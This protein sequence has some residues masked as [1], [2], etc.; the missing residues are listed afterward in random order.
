MINDVVN[1]YFHDQASIVRL[2]IL[3]EEIGETK[4]DTL[5]LLIGE[6]FSDND[7]GI[8]AEM[9]TL[10]QQIEAECS[11]NDQGI[12]DEMDTLNQ[13]IKAECSDNDQGISDEMNTSNQQIEAKFSNDDSNV[14]S[15]SEEA[16]SV[17]SQR[18]NC[19][20]D[21]AEAIV[22]SSGDAGG[23][24]ADER[25]EVESGKNNFPLVAEGHVQEVRPTTPV[26]NKGSEDIVD[27]VVSSTLD[28]G[29]KFIVEGTKV[30]DEGEDYIIEK[31][32]YFFEGEEV[33]SAVVSNDVEH[34]AESEIKSQQTLSVPSKNSILSNQKEVEEPSCRKVD[35][36]VLQACKITLNDGVSENSETET[37]AQIVR[38]IT[39]V[40]HSGSEDIVDDIVSSSDEE[41]NLVIDEE[42]KVEKISAL[43][44]DVEYIAESEVESQLILAAPS[45]KRTLDRNAGDEPL[46]KREKSALEVEQNGKNTSTEC[47][48]FKP[49]PET[50][51]TEKGESPV[52]L[53]NSV[54]KEA[55]TYLRQKEPSTPV[56]EPTSEIEENLECERPSS[57]VNE[58][59]TETENNLAEIPTTTAIANK[60][61][62]LNR[63]EVDELP[64]MKSDLGIEQTGKNTV[65]KFDS[66]P[67][68]SK[69]CES[70]QEEIPIIPVISSDTDDNFQN[71]RPPLL[72]SLS[73]EKRD[74]RPPL[75]PSP[76]VKASDSRSESIRV[77]SSVK[78]SSRLPRKP[79]TNSQAPINLPTNRM[80]GPHHPMPNQP[81]PIMFAN[82]Q[83]IPNS[84]SSQGVRNNLPVPGMRNTFNNQRMQQMQNCRPPMNPNL[85][86]M[87]PNLQQ[88]NLNMKQVNL[89]MGQVN[90]NL[91]QVNPNLQQV[92]LNMQQMNP[93]MQQMNF[94]MPQM[95]LKMQ[96]MNPNLQQMNL[97]MPQMNLKMQQMIPNMQQMIPNMQLMNI[98]FQ[99]FNNN[100]PPSQMPHQFQNQAGPQFRQ[101]NRLQLSPF[102]MK[103]RHPQNNY[104]FQIIKRKMF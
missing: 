96:Q 102:P 89:N 54:E 26:R 87:N 53:V 51:V 10:N 90:P 3:A 57:L 21:Q 35:L 30:I 64:R 62:T 39:Q 6:L 95:N 11:D 104:P 73:P 12:S 93:N 25:E 9:N 33:D 13:Q 20:S 63:N 47:D 19:R 97:N 5:V 31:E 29:E 15:G 48:N 80:F 75:L 1:F 94:N 18:S 17:Q 70:I 34:F 67:E 72:E 98:N 2:Y 41:G 78:Q 56:N 61:Q 99:P 79:S 59:I 83:N 49:S 100:C 65:N 32:E 101:N 46:R 52:T 23:L 22:I 81:Q 24:V 82:N 55:Q 74:S 16:E 37:R 92:N 8:S 42:K 71:K 77:A 60:K 7:Q 86:Q 36:G 4:F 85:Q 66:S 14:L 91:Q 44:N 84:Q 58:K 40:K 50:S 76:P 45:N 27:D 43:S 88:M 38:P 68:N 28:E 69:V 103:R